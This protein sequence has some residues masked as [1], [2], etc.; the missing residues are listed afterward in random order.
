MG[1]NAG[2]PWSL[3]DA[4]MDADGWVMGSFAVQS[5]ARIM[6]LINRMRVEERIMHVVILCAAVFVSVRFRAV[7]VA[8]VW[9]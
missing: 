8:A 4:Y 1:S 3:P 5:K 6:L 7:E 9:V 2:L